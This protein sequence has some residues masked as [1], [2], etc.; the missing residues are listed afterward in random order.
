MNRSIDNSKEQITRFKE[1]YPL[2]KNI[3]DF[4]EGILIEQEKTKPYTDINKIE[5]R[6]D[7]RELQ[8]REGFPLLDKKDFVLDLTTSVKLLENI[9]RIS[10]VANEKMRGNI[11]AIE[12]AVTINAISLKELLKRHYD[13][14]FIDGIAGEFDIDRAIMKFLILTSIQPSVHMNMEKLKDLV[15]LKKWQRGYCPVCGS[16]PQISELKGEGQRYFLCSFCSFEWPGERLKCPFCENTDN[17]SL[18]YF[19]AEGDEAH[20]IE[21]CDKCSQYIKT[22]D[23]R[24]LNYDPDLILEDIATIHLDLLAVEQGFK[25][26]TLSYLGV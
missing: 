14:T 12:E 16:L 3:L 11:Q 26:P 10:K 17:N 25:R 6:G 21:L 8:A 18:H 19:F 23:S 15:D 7:L 20:R 5:I 2:Y 9:C 13:E 22:V 1:K 24:K 4:Y